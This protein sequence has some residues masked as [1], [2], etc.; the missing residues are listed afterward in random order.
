MSDVLADSP[1]EKA[2][3]QRGDVILTVNGE[4][5]KNNQ[6]FVSKIRQ[7]LAGEKVTLGIIR[8]KKK[9]DVPV[10]LG[11]MPG[12]EGAA[13]EAASAGSKCSRTLVS[14]W[15]PFQKKFRKSTI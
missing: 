6:E 10:T 7:R 4:K 11:E 15:L 14:K 13:I 2:G 9:I 8:Q 1:A 12:N 3:L 5:V